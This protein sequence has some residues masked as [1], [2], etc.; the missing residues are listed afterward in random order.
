MR[1]K[2][3]SNIDF[4]NRL[5][6][7]I[8]HVARETLPEEAVDEVN[9][10]TGYRVF[11]PLLLL[12]DPHFEDKMKV[13][14]YD[15]VRSRNMHKHTPSCFKYGHKSCRARFPRRLVPANTF[16]ED[17]GIIMTERNDPWL[18]GYN[19][20][21]AMM[22]QANHDVQFL[23][24]KDHA[25]AAMYYINKYISKPEASTHSKLT[26]AAAVWKS[27]SEHT[28]AHDVDIAK[29]YYTKRIIN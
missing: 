13:D 16:D 8:Y 20:V 15:I 21:L 14:V 18:N 12:E 5:I 22:T 1:E 26:I 4:R 9:S 7:F 3:K 6:D 28:F 24:T 29:K 25:L 19:P 10:Q 23:S 2:A 11:Q 17:T 27:L